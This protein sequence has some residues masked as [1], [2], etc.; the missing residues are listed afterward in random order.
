MERTRLEDVNLQ[1]LRRL[2]QLVT[3]YDYLRIADCPVGAPEWCPGRED[4]PLSMGNLGEYAEAVVKGLDTTPYK[5][6]DQV[7]EKCS[8][9]ATDFREM[10]DFLRSEQKSD[11]NI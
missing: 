9:C 11:L 7:I 10:M 2:W 3:S 5:P 4:A 1:K 6:L 8:D